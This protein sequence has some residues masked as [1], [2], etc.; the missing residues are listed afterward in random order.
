M[1]RTTIVR[2]TIA[3]LAIGFFAAPIA[4][5]MVG[6]TAEAFENRKFA[7]APKLSQGWDAFQQTSQFLT[8]RMP[9]RAQ[10]VRANTRIWTDVFDT[11]PRYGQ[12]T[13]LADDQA[14]PFAGDAE[15]PPDPNEQTPQQKAAQV[16]QGEDGWLYLQGELDRACGAFVPFERAIAR[17]LALT[18]T[19]RASGRDVVLIVAP[20]KASVY[21]EHLPEEYASDDCAL[22]EK[23]RF[24]GLLER[25]ERR[26]AAVALR[27]DLVRA[28][29]RAG[30]DLFARKDSHWTTLGSLTLVRAALDSVG[31]GVRMRAGEIVDPGRAAYQGDLTVLLGT[32]E[33]DTRAE[34]EIRRAAAAPRVPGRTLLVGDSFGDAPLGPLRAYF[35]QLDHALLVVTPLRRIAAQVEAADTV[36]LETVERDFT[37]RASDGGVVEALRAVLRKRLTDR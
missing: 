27:D 10:A 35:G 8:D 32:P 25:A 26:G 34:R 37:F 7:E 9:L 11:T 24:W 21:P 23:D 33:A 18:E 1:A 5:R 19:I 15:Q 12:Q 29:T 14:L 36:I 16:L 30:D 28:K 13:M 4:A 3:A 6:I 17:W 20:D 22:A 2:L 31:G